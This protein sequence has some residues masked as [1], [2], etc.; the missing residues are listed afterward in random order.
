MAKNLEPHEASAAREDARSLEAEADTGEPYPDDTVISPSNQASRMFN[1][2]L[3]EERFAAI[4]HVAERQ[5]LR[6]PPWLT[7]GFLKASEV[8][9]G[10]AS[11]LFEPV[12]PLRQRSSV[13]AT[14]VRT[15]ARA[16]PRGTPAM[17]S[18]S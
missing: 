12:Q 1:V 18:A 11:F 10:C 13:A 17:S 8:A 7:L 6:C 9:S 4:Q 15:C 3:S 2:R 14:R 16:S 5:H